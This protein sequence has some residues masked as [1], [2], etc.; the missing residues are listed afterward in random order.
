MSSSARNLGFWA[1]A[2]SDLYSYDTG[3]RVYGLGTG[4]GG[5][6]RQKK[7][8]KTGSGCG[9]SDGECLFSQPIHLRPEASADIDPQI[10]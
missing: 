9:G 3:F 10:A 4:K 2:V 1:A 8:P 5:G 7:G 6:G